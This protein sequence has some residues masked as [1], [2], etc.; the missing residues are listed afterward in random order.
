MILREGARK[1]LA[2]LGCGLWLASSFMPLFGGTA[3]HQVRCGGRQFTGEF[4]DCFN[5]YI[6]VLEL[7]TPIVALLLLY[8]FARLA[9]GTW[10]PEPDC[11]RQRWRLAPAAGSAVYH[12]GFLL[13]CATGAIWSA[14]RGVLY[15]L[16]LMTLPFMA[17][18]AAFA[19]WFAAGA[20]VTWRAARTQ[21]LG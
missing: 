9:F 11:R 17:F 3:K 16:D 12:P 1:A 13:F 14:W 15:P 19:T 18:W 5:D 20:I 6:P 10:S 7:I 21:N 2:L 8:S 4:D